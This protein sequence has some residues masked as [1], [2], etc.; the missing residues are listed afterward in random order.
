VSS[1]SRPVTALPKAEV[2]AGLFD[3]WDGIEDL[4][5]SLSEQEWRLPTSL[6]GWTVH[7]V[8][9]HLVGTES[10][11]SG[12]PTPDVDVSGL[13]HVRNEIG[14][15][16]EAWVRSLESL[17]GVELLTRFAAVTA[18]RRGA[19]SAMGDDEWNAV[20][21]TPAGPDSYGRFMRIRT[22]DCWV[23]ELDIRDALD[24]PATDVELDC[25]A[26]RCALDEMAASMGFVIG[27]RG[28]A[29]D[30]SRVV[31]E[32][33]GPL[34]RTIRVAVDGRAAVVDD[35]GGI[36]PTAVIRLDALDFVRLCGGRVATAPIEFEGDA[37]VG[38]RIVENLNYII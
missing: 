13:A 25:V 35:F 5:S 6:S 16:N 27:K 23:H 4:T 33:T 29:P 3:S 15:M 19:L 22:F 30:G 8:V 12:T 7:N 37:E 38:Q 34:A 28:K 32:L 14:A 9:A 21:L 24:C 20:G 26:A 18:Q 2:L 10:M 1:P 36:A 31:L 11:L 17:S